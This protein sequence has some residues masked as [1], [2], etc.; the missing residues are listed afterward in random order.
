MLTGEC[1]LFSL[2]KAL[3]EDYGQHHTM[4]YLKEEIF[5]EIRRGSKLYVLFTAGSVKEMY[6]NVL[7]YLKDQQFTNNTIDVVVIAASKALKLNLFIY[8]RNR[9]ED[10]VLL[11]PAMCPGSQIN[12]LLKYN[13]AGGSFH[14]FDHYEPVLKQKISSSLPPAISTNAPVTYHPEDLVTKLLPCTLGSNAST[15]ILSSRNLSSSQEQCS[16]TADHVS[17]S[18][19]PPSQGLS[20]NQKQCSET[21]DHASTSQIPSSQGLSFSQ[22]QRNETADH[23][24]IILRNMVSGCADDR[25]GNFYDEYGSGLSDKATNSVSTA[26]QIESSES[27]MTFAEFVGTDEQDA[28]PFYPNQ[29]DSDTEDIEKPTQDIIINTDRAGITEI[30]EK[31]N[32][33]AR[34]RKPHH[35]KHLQNYVR[36]S[37]MPLKMVDTVPWDVDGD[38]HFKIQCDI[39]SWVE[40]QRDGHWYKMNLSKRKGFNGTRK[41]SYCQGSWICHNVDC[42]KLQSEGICNINPKEFLYDN[43]AYVCNPCGYYAVQIYCGAHKVTEFNRDTNELDIWFEGTHNCMPKPDVA[44][45][46]NYF[47]TLLLKHNL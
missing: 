45:K 35:S 10:S 7:A 3:S 39:D 17:P 42:L 5:E 15:E 27:I 41:V 29:G 38:H 19:I 12:I 21:A 36:C 28:M 20:C 34:V 30:P 26:H 31:F 18:Q 9:L 8:S 40:Q 22:K 11:V 4:E 44:N 25:E 16:E 23:E 37:Q 1:F 6:Y 2:Q 33:K 13:R 43:G 46:C 24:S 14:G 32:Y 47:E